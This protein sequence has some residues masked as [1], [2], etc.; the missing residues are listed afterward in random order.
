MDG[1][2]LMI[3]N[4]D[5]LLKGVGVV[6]KK[7]KEERKEQKQ[8]KAKKGKK[9]REESKVVDRDAGLKSVGG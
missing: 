5:A 9:K 1:G 7:K 3:Q 4:Y 8:Q 6:V 2:R